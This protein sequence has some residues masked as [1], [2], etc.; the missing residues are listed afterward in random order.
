[1]T[2]SLI[3]Q[4]T[5]SQTIRLC[6]ALLIGINY[7]GGKSP[8]NGCINDVQNVRNWLLHRNPAYGQ[9]MLVLTDDQ[10]DP[11]KIPTRANMLNAFRWLAA[12]A[13]PGDHLFFHYSGHGA[14]QKNLDGTEAS[15]FDETLVPVDYERAG[16]IVDDDVHAILCKPLPQGCNLVAFMDCCHSGTVF[17]LPYTY[18]VDGNLDITIR[19][20]KAEAVKH[21]TKAFFALLQKDNTTALREVESAIKLFI[22]PDQQQQSAPNEEMAR[23]RDTTRATIVQFSGCRDDQTSADAQIQGRA[24]GA[25]SWALM[26][27]LQRNPNPT[28]TE[29]LRETRGLLQGKYS[30]VPQM[31]TGFQVMLQWSSGDNV[32]PM[33]GAHC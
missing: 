11:S 13:R 7:I 17:D 18:G 25:L 4:L 20:N 22:T 6:Q 21:G 33:T 10:Q 9:N 27:V 1:M 14:T 12:D 24:S 3:C 8:L 15:G 32:G 16:Q 23:Q 26:T 28:Y 29:L 30:Q 2:H 19:D 5:D 31:S